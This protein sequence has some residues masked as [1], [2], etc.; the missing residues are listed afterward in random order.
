MA[1]ISEEELKW[2][3]AEA[4]VDKEHVNQLSQN[5]ITF[6]GIKFLLTRSRSTSSSKQIDNDG[7]DLKINELIILSPLPVRGMIKCV[8]KKSLMSIK[9][10]SY[11]F[12][13]RSRQCW[14]P[15]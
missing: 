11:E 7:Y 9:K 6:K 12:I 2:I 8:Y 1:K 15:C 5:D 3:N 14:E 10:W 4:M 13:L